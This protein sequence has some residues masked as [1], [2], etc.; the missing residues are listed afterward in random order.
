MWRVS[1]SGRFS[2]EDRR[3]VTEY[4]IISAQGK[5]NNHRKE[6]KTW[7]EGIKN[8]LYQVDTYFVEVMNSI[9]KLKV[10]KPEMEEWTLIISNAI[11]SIKYWAWK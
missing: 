2:K 9:E 7:R 10:E 8:A 1:L 4:K 3:N 11:N 6:Y 5:L